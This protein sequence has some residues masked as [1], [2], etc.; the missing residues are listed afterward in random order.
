[1]PPFAPA[2]LHGQT[3]TFVHRVVTGTDDYGND[4][5]TATSVDVPGCAVSPGSSSED[6][7]G[8][9][10][11]MSDVLVHA[12]AA[13]LVD[14]PFDEMIIGGQTFNIVGDPR[15]WVSPFTGSGGFLEVQGKLITTGGAA[16]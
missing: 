16:T 14:L 2:L 13:T 10:Q 6:W 15:S 7:Q 11:V 4:V 12:P 3:V 5:Y 1:M 9:L 8:T